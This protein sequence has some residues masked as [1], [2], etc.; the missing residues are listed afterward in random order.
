MS[1]PTSDM[2]ASPGSRL[3]RKL[4]VQARVKAHRLWQVPEFWETAVF[5]GVGLEVS[6]VQ[7]D[8]RDRSE[9]EQDVQFAQLGFFAYNMMS[10]GVS[11]AQ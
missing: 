10:F 1:T 9:R 2:V 3:T 8:I 11:E 6:K 4:Y 7:P 5:D